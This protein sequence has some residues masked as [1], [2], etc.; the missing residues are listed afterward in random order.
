MRRSARWDTQRNGCVEKEREAYVK[1]LGEAMT[2][3]KAASLAA[4]VEASRTR[5]DCALEET[6]TMAWSLWWRWP[7]AE[8]NSRRL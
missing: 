3:R 4:N 6:E 1:E 2:A 7:P 8:R 5:N